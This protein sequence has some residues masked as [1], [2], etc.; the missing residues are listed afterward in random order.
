MLEIE[1]TK[2]DKDNI[3]A[4]LDK[5]HLV[6]KRFYLV[7]SKSNLTSFIRPRS[8]SL[9]IKNLVGNMDILLIG[10]TMSYSTAG[11]YKLLKSFGNLITMVSTL[12]SEKLRQK[13]IRDSKKLKD[14]LLFSSV[15]IIVGLIMGLMIYLIINLN[16]DYL[17]KYVSIIKIKP[18]FIVFSLLISISGIYRVYYLYMNSMVWNLFSQIA[19]LFSMIYLF[20]TIP[21]TLY[22]YLIYPQLIALMFFIVHVKKNN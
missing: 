7:K 18:I 13:Y 2:I 19:V 1:N 15:L 10:T 11:E 6:I 4:I 22:P 8:L 14:L 21:N 12:I 3:N 20:F 16:M 9:L 5:Y 17:S